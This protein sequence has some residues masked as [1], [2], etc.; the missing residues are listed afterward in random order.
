M[1]HLSDTTR[2]GR[3]TLISL[4]N[5]VGGGLVLFLVVL[6]SLVF[7]QNQASVVQEEASASTSTA[8]DTALFTV[9]S[10]TDGDTIKV[11]IDGAVETVRIVNINTPETVDPRKPVECMGKE[12]S[13]KMT[14]LASGKKVLLE[15]DET[16]AEKDRYDRLLRFVFLEDGTDVG[17]EMVR[18]GFAHSSP[19]GSTPHK[20]IE[21]YS[22][23]QQEAQEKKL[24]LWNPE[25]CQT[26]TSKPT[27]SSTTTIQPTV[28]GTSTESEPA[29]T[30]NTSTLIKK[31][32]SNICHAPG[33]SSYEKTTNYT[34]YNSIDDCMES[35]GRLPKR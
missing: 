33:T 35:G 28:Q 32:T 12:A 26:A 20:Y 9:T 18:L 29:E 27:T 13:A 10:V 22:Q 2:L 19:Y 6:F 25:H 34:A 8:P 30:T 17:L 7:N 31:S 21:A 3:K 23:A 14:E 1:T 16:Q 11:S 4:K 15:I 5:L 24:G